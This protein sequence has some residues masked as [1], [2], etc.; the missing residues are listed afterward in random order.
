[1][2]DI[3]KTYKGWLKDSEY[4]VDYVRDGYTG[5]GSLMTMGQRAASLVLDAGV[6]VQVKLGNRVSLSLENQVTWSGLDGLDAIHLDPRPTGGLSPDK[7]WVNNL[8]LGVGINLGNKKRSVLPLWW[9]NP[10]DHAYWELS[11]PRH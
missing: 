9:V 4:D 1:N 11:D 7:D 10:L 6:G 8:S 3:N 5:G 2:K